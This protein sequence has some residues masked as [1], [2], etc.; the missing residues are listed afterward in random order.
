MTTN[1]QRTKNERQN[2]SLDHNLLG[3]LFQQRYLRLS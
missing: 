1:E 3:K 2:F